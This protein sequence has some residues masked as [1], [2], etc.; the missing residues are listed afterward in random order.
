MDLSPLWISLKIALTATVVTFVLGL[1]AAWG[2]MY[3]RRAKYVVD[4]ILSVPLVLPP[5]VVGFLLLILF[6][7]NSAFGRFLTS[8][9]LNVIFTW[10]GAVIAAAVPVACP[11][12][13]IVPMMRVATSRNA[14]AR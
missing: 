3:L 14:G 2:V 6:G 1:V 4:G 13:K 9:G 5:T 8:I 7:Q 10:Q 12:V 11:M